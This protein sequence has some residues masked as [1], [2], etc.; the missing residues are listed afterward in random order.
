[1]EDT[2]IYEYLNAGTAIYEYLNAD[3]AIYEYLN[4]GHCNIRIFKWRTL[5]YTN[6]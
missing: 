1:M 5:Q 6:I 3:T 2:A 4:G